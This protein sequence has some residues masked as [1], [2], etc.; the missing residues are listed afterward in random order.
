MFSHSGYT[1]SK[2]HHR[3]SKIVKRIGSFFRHETRIKKS[4]LKSN[5]NRESNFVKRL[6][7]L[8]S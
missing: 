8:Q 7:N 3:I 4:I 6:V 1:I 2:H 5:Q